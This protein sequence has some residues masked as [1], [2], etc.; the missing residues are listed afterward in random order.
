MGG[1]G[2]DAKLFDA[3][4]EYSDQERDGQEDEGVRHLVCRVWG[5][6]FCSPTGVPPSTLQGYFAHENP[7]P[8]RTL[9]VVLWRRE[10]ERV[11][12]LV[13]RVWSLGFR[14]YRV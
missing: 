11:R 14:V 1:G 5:S 3:E 10:D 9:Q 2:T 12:H 8:H 6:G 4:E 13:Y 7:P